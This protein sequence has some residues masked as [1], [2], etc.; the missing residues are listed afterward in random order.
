MLSRALPGHHLHHQD[1]AED[2]VL[3]LQSDRALPPHLLDGHPWLHSPTR[4]GREA[5]TGCAIATYGL[6]NVMMMDLTEETNFDTFP[7][8]E[9][10]IMLAITIF[11]TIV[12]DMLPVTDSTPLIGDFLIGIQCFFSY[13]C[14]YV[15]IL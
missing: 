7:L 12:G 9:V 4:L 13:L 5:G 15:H 6:L 11:A 8:T 2:D 3:L 1:P 14:L 10:T